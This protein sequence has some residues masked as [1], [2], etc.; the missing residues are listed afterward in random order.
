MQRRDVRETC[1]VGQF[2]VVNGHGKKVT[3]SE[4]IE[5]IHSRHLTPITRDGSEIR[6]MCNSILSLRGGLS[7]SHQDCVDGPSDLAA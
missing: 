1:R 4:C 6:R 2:M 7:H 5:A 3:A